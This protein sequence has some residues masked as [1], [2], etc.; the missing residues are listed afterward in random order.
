M[1]PEEE[2]KKMKENV[3]GI[4]LSQ[5]RSYSQWVLSL[6]FLKCPSLDSLIV[7]L[8][9]ALAHGVAPEGLG[10]AYKGEAPDYSLEECWLQIPEITKGVDA[11]YIYS[12]VYVES[13]FAEGSSDY[14]RL[15]N[16]EM[17][18][19]AQ[20][21]YM[22]NA[23]VFEESANVF[24]PY[25]RQAGMRYAGEVSKETGDIDAAISGVTYDDVTAALDY[26]FEN[27][28]EGRPFIIGP[29]IW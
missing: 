28:N 19:G 20:E 7:T 29:E 25:Y 14:A 21:E 3:S 4:P 26:Y 5:V 27:C 18:L 9:H 22:T 12:T 23:S 24:A 17:V 11:L 15:D 16:P 8:F 2:A 10:T 6:S 1:L 13:S